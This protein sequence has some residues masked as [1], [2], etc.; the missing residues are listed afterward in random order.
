MTSNSDF[1]LEMIDISKSFGNTIALSDVDLKVKKGTIHGLIGQNGA[2]KSTLMKILSG[3]YPT[4]T[5]SG[6][7]IID[8]KPVELHSAL[9]AQ[10]VGISIVPQE[11]TVADT[12]TVAENILLPEMSKSPL[13]PYNKSGAVSKVAA[14]LDSYNIPLQPDKLVA[15]LTLAEKQILMIARAIYLKPEV[16]VLDE[17]TS[18][19]TGDEIKN[20]FQVTRTLKS[21]GITTVFITHKMDEIIELCDSVSILR[22][23]KIVCQVEKSEF[24]VDV[25]VSHMI[26]RDLGDLYPS[27]KLVGSDAPVVLKVTDLVI[28]NP[29]KPG[30]PLL[31]PFSFELRKGEILGIG[32]LVGSGRTEIA[33]SL[34]GHYRILNGA[35][36]VEGNPIRTRSVS[37]SISHGFGYITEDRKAE[38][39]FFN[40]AIKEN[41]TA[42][43]LN[44]LTNLSFLMKGSERSRAQVFLQSL[45]VKPQNLEAPISSLS[46][47]NQQKV[48][49]GKSLITEP[50]ILMLDEPT[51]GVDIA[52]KAEIYKTIVEYANEGYAVLLISSEFPELLAMSHRVIVFSGGELVG[53]MTG[54]LDKEKDLMLMAIGATKDSS[55]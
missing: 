46:G 39:L 14:F 3:L 41:F 1:A 23:G 49:L 2:G 36:E 18:S 33:K 50:R 54:G 44:I 12:L 40:L 4:G 11:T 35:V 31:K 21:L 24:E 28:E 8:G 9:D 20:L 10:S 47:G 27:Q 15:S 55:N 6:Q 13:K 32:G 26:G 17:P 37:E 48:V 29:R 25:L 53:E 5:Y 45:Q 22:D 7:I 38:G 16:L 30:K 19:L 34:F 43:I 42:S 51:K 52:S